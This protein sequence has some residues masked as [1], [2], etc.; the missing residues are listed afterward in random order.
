[1]VW[2]LEIQNF[3]HI[4]L[5]VVKL[6]GFLFR[7][8]II[9][10]EIILHFDQFLKGHSYGTK[11][12]NDPILFLNEP[13]HIKLWFMIGKSTK[14]GKSEWLFFVPL[15]K[16]CKKYCKNCWFFVDP[17]IPP[18]QGRRHSTFFGRHFIGQLK[19]SQ[20]CV[21]YFHDF[22]SIKSCHT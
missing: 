7:F 8:T 10:H 11:H 21:G 6:W 13:W 4:W 16:L 9:F 15:T 18:S 14:M 2:N 22:T 3:K 20:N 17:R 1:M 19:N 5:L 12:D